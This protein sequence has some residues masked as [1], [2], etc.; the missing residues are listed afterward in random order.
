[1]RQP[2]LRLGY[3]ARQR[4]QEVRARHDTDKLTIAHHENTIDLVA[5]HKVHDLIEPTVFLYRLH[6]R[7]HHVADLAASGLQI[8]CGQASRTHQKF[9][10]TPA[11]ALCPRFRTPAEIPPSYDRDRG[12]AWIR[13]RQAAEFALQ[14]QPDGVGDRSVR[15]NRYGSGGHDVSGPHGVASSFEFCAC[16]SA[17]ARLLYDGKNFERR[18]PYAHA[19]YQSVRS[20]SFGTC[21]DCSFLRS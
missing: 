21:D 12:A 15:R 5:F 13:D 1:A 20:S 7:S 4:V 6:V 17:G 14:H 8:L 19:S 9:D 18:G 3:D 11:L 16:L 10:P 2:W